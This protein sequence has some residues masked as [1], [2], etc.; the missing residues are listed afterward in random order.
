MW[1][2]LIKFSGLHQL[3]NFILLVSSERVILLI[4]WFDAK[5]R[6]KH[7]ICSPNSHRTDM[8]ISIIFV[9]QFHRLTNF[10]YKTYNTKFLPPL[11][12]KIFPLHWFLQIA[13]VKKFR[14]H[15]KFALPY[16]F[17]KLF[18]VKYNITSQFSP[19]QAAK[20]H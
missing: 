5:S 2:N 17:L 20:E 6:L 4:I 11:K 12:I 15:Q 7:F 9:A 10:L 18:L 1:V 3:L 8:R 14:F 13:G 19:K 16:L